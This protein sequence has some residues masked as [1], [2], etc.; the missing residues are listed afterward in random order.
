MMNLEAMI[1]A[2]IGKMLSKKP[3]AMPSAETAGENKLSHRLMHFKVEPPCYT[4][5]KL[6]VAS[7]YVRK[8]YSEAFDYQEEQELRHQ[9]SL[10][11]DIPPRASSVGD[12]FEHY[13]NRHL[14]AGGEFSMRSLDGRFE[15]DNTFS[16]DRDPNIQRDFRMHGS[17]YLLYTLSKKFS[18]Y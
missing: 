12:S 5:Y 6:V 7:E 9:F 16:T 8:K 14:S 18:V 15:R 17:W 1:D 3:M 11:K 13:V 2:K 4:E 10:H